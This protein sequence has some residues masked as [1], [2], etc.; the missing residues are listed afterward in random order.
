MT[1]PTPQESASMLIA[2]IRHLIPHSHATVAEILIAVAQHIEADRAAH[3]RHVAAHM[4]DSQ[5][6]KI[7]SIMR[8]NMT[9]GNKI[10]AIHEVMKGTP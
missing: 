9:P 1:L 4:Y 10:V 8:R 2:S 6:K 5:L 3:C 7:A